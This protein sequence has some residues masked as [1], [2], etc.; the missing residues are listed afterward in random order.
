MTYNMKRIIVCAVVAFFSVCTLQAKVG[1][2]I[3]QNAELAIPEKAL[4][5]RAEIH[6]K[7]GDGSYLIVVFRNEDKVI[8]KKKIKIF[9]WETNL[10]KDVQYARSIKSIERDNDKIIIT[11]DGGNTYKVDIP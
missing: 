2:N 10:E 1:G 8:T 6:T 4:K 5:V 9:N 3:R 7:R 11:V